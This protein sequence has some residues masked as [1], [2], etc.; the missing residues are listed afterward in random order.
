MQA[1][2][3]LCVGRAEQK[4]HFLCGCAPVEML[5]WEQEEKGGGENQK[6]KRGFAAA[7][8][9]YHHRT[10]E[11]EKHAKTAAHSTPSTS[12]FRRD[13]SPTQH[14]LSAIKKKKN[15]S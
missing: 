7:T 4:A 5:I 10:C 8:S 11:R 13:I 3:R 6:G 1:P 2:G 9:M 14:P 12:T 15:K